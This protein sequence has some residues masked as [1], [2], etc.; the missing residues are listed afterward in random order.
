VLG[1]DLVAL[2]AFIRE[3]LHLQ[4][5][6]KFSKVPQQPNKTKNASKKNTYTHISKKL[7]TT[8]TKEK[9]KDP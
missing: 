2:E 8:T 3:A 6:P 9:L 7:V 1:V 4:V 5:W